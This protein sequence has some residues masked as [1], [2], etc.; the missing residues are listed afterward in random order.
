MRLGLIARA[1]DG[2]LGVQTWELARHLD[3]ARILIVRIGDQRGEFHPERFDGLADD[4]R[5]V[6]NPPEPDHMRWLLDGSDAVFTVEGCYQER[7]IAMARGR[8]IGLWIYANPELY[9]KAYRELADDGVIHV[10]APTPWETERLG[11]H[12]VLPMPVARDRIPFRARSGPARVF[13][14]TSAPAM[15]DRNGSQFVRA[16][17]ASYNEGP[18]GPDIELHVS[19]PEAPD[20]RTTVGHVTV[21]PA[22]HVV[23]YWDRYDHA[24]VLVVPRRYGGLSLVMQEALAAGMPVIAMDRYPEN[25]WP[26]V[27]TVPTN[28]KSLQRMKGGD[29]AVWSC[30]PAVLALRM[31]L[32]AVADMTTG[33]MRA[34][35]HADSISWDRMLGRWCS[36]LDLECEAISA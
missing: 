19:G 3:P 9:P 23:N 24:D 32:A 2:G 6:Q 11:R 18:T 17:V 12:R 20:E 7:L 30:N 15:L 4:L 26:G 36:R 13:L 27:E 8:G 1:D 22:P 25:T 29:I 35:R 14:H 16:A 28:G 34:D 5:V 33:S 21:V 10:L 31:K